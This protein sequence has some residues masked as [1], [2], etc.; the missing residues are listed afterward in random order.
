MKVTMFVETTKEKY[1]EHV[2]SYRSLE[3]GGRV[4]T[5]E[6]DDDVTDMMQVRT[7]HNKHISTIGKPN[8][9]EFGWKLIGL[10]IYQ[11]YLHDGRPRSEHNQYFILKEVELGHHHKEVGAWTTR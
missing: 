11:R 2:V 3:H 6:F 4:S 1:D 10:A 9:R 7:Y 8:W 5:R